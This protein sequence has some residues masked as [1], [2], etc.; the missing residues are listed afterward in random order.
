M[1]K[2][3][4]FYYDERIKNKK[5]MK[6]VKKYRFDGIFLMCDN[7]FDFNVQLAKKYS[8]FIESAHLPYRDIANNLWS[9]DLVGEE[10]TNYIIEWIRRVSKENIKIAV[11]HTSAGKNPPA[12]NEIGIERLK[13]IVKVCEEENI[14][15]AIENIRYWDY[16]LRP[17][18]IIN[19]PNLGLCFDFGHANGFT[20]N[21][22]ELDYN[23]LASKVKCVHIHDNFGTGDDHL[24]PF[25][26]NINFEFVIN[27]L[28]EYE[29]K[30]NITLELESEK[31][32]K[33]TKEYLG[34]AK[35]SVQR[36]GE[37]Y[38]K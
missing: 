13:R 19:S 9:I 17:L 18:S 4:N 33:N 21:I 11:M 6:L 22:Y 30:G 20:K 12:M 36:L 7:D 35:L 23:Y 5:R 37:I 2:I 24:V 31:K 10:Y 16:V 15:L 3:I 1:K 26:G 32:Y 38:E 8:L 34:K 27:K 25:D 14:T 29:F 28:K